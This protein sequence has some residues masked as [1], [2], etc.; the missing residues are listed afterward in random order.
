VEKKLEL[1]NEQMMIPLQPYGIIHTLLHRS[2]HSLDQRVDRYHDCC[3]GHARG[4]AQHEPGRG[5]CQREE[6][7]QV[8]VQLDERRRL[9]VVQRGVEVP[10]RVVGETEPRRRAR[11]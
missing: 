6:P 3:D 1:K 10:L 5:E 8:P 2:A 11:G 9:D 4:G 7:V